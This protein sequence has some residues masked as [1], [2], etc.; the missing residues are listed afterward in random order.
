MAFNLWQ[1]LLRP[2]QEEQQDHERTEIVRA[3]NLLEIGEFQLLQVAYLE[4]FGAE[5]PDGM[6]DI[7]FQQYMVKSQV[8]HWARHFAREVLRLDLVGELNWEDKRYH[9]FDHQHYSATP[10]PGFRKMLIA[11]LSIILFMGG[12]LVLANVSIDKSISLFPPYL[13]E[14]DF[15]TKSNP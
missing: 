8:P 2:D 6:I 11:V 15:G 4:W 12:L 1:T 9:V 5:M 14:N 13:D 3:A 7:V 10:K